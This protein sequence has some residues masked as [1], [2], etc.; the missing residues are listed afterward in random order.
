[1]ACLSITALADEPIKVLQGKSLFG[2]PMY[3]VGSN[4]VNVAPTEKLLRASA[5]AKAAYENNPTIDTATWYGRVLSYQGLM[6]EAIVVYTA[7][8][9]RYPNSAKLLRH[10]AHRYFNLREFDKSI[11]DGLRSAALFEGRPLEREKLGPDYFPS[12]ADVVQFYLYYHLGHAYFAEHKYDDAAKW[13]DK[14]RQVAE[15]TGDPSSVTAG[16]YWQY[17]SLARGQR[18]DDAKALLDGHQLDLIDL[19]DN[20]ESNNYFDG[21]QLFKNLRDPATFYSTQDSGKAFSTSDGISSS[22]AYS[23]AN[24]YILRGDTYKA[25]DYLR[26]S[27]DIETWSFFARVQAES[28]WLHLYGQEKP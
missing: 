22:T 9:K 7:G 12:S 25:K 27:M 10:R 24:Y 1:M 18:Y 4:P 17:L 16:T 11:E 13:F 15:G 19:K 20:I 8:L 6:R 23:L 2:E 3:T 5:E 14:A 26:K 28:D 21:I